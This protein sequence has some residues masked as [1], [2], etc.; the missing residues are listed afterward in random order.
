MGADL[1]IAIAY[2]SI[3]FAL[4]FFAKRRPDIPQR[5][6]V[7]LFGLFVMACGTTHLFDVLNIWHPSYW[8]D[9]LVRVVTAGLS[10]VTA[11]VLW[12]IMPAALAA[13]STQQLEAAN[14]QLLR[15][16]QY[17]RSLIEASLDP[18]VT[19]NPEGKIMDVNRA[20]ESI[21]GVDRG[22][23]IG[24]DFSEYF[25]EPDKAR[26][27]YQEVY[28]K[29]WVIDYPLAIR[30][31]AGKETEVVY[32]A[33]VYQDEA[34]HVAG[35]FAAARDMTQIKRAEKQLET[36]NQE[37]EAFAYSVSHDLRAPLRGIDGWS[38]ALLEDYGPQLDEKA[39]GY[40]DVVR[41]ETQRMG[42]LID[43]L[44]QLSRVGRAEFKHAS[45]DLSALAG[46][47]AERLRQAQPERAIEFVI[48]PGLRGEG[49]EHLL[50]IVLTN[51]LGNACKFTAPCANPRIEFGRSLEQTAQQPAGA[52]VLVVSDNGVGFEMAHAQK[53]FGAF[54]RLHKASEFPGTGIGLATVQRIVHR[55][56]GKI[57]AEAQPGLG[58]R[59]Y[60]TLGEG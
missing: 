58:A 46:V 32:N 2:F 51:L 4:W 57:W 17:A 54:Q 53:L 29:G 7:V 56:H 50:D 18:L 19:I 44:L 9:A 3:P 39:R 49:D 41:S 16:S 47:V 52:S 35:V 38:L 15:A 28:E 48:E 5:W 37:L 26:Q 25:T 11:V 45:V 59:F 30:H 36:A 13:P 21:T 14:R 34:G 20:T 24:S 40:L 27:G 43:D 42:Q 10:L 33:T 6:L 55:H 8:A 23:L 60:F 1:T 12:R 22:Q 31:V